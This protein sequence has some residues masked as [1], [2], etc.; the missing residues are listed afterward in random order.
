MTSSPRVAYIAAG[1]AGMFCGS[2]LRDN[3]LA[4]AL[5]EA[6][7]NVVLIPTFTPLQTETTDQSLDRIFLGGIN[8]YLADKLGWWRSLPAFV[9][10]AFDHP[11]L[12][13]ML[14]AMALESRSDD[15][16]ALSISLMQGTE[17]RHQRE[18]EELADWLADDLRPD[19][20]NVSNLFVAGFASALKKRRDIPILVTLQGDELFLDD[21]RESD[22]P[23]VVEEMRRVARTVDGFIVFSRFYRD[24]MMEMLNL[25]EELFH[26]APLGLEA[27]TD[28]FNAASEK[29]PRSSQRPLTLG[30]LARIY[31]AK[32][33]HLLVDAFLAIRQRF[34]NLRLA[35]G[36]WLGKADRPYFEEQCRRIEEAGAGDAFVYQPLPD[37]QA[38]VA[39]LQG[40]DVFS[41]PVTYPEQKGL[42]VLEALAA[43]VPVVLPDVGALPEMLTD[44]GGGCLVPPND[45][46]ALVNA[47]AQ[48]L[49]DD[50]QR[51]RLGDEGRRGVLA[52]RQASMMAEATR[53]VYERLTS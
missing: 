27:A 33:F 39:F 35:V 45:P 46:G 43:G 44:T 34:P 20:V 13:R 29:K 52:T 51:Q 5:R 11:R 9:H 24:F 7:Q 8:L 10:R 2:C 50:E 37:R 26:V 41:V 36:G 53:L 40:I 15:D 25:P 42:Y 18:I 31:P 6:G 12:L 23:A 3:A 48:L 38:K 21:I 17:S 47:I 19:L 14:S 1:S 22:R 28:F 4:A 32:G 16:A 30:Y 49:Q